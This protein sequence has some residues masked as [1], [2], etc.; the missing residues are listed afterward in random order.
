MLRQR[1]GTKLF[2]WN[3]LGSVGEALIAHI[4]TEGKVNNVL[5]IVNGIRV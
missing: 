2:R 1:Y 5:E 4:K 3:E